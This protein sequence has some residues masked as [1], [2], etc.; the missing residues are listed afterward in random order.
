MKPIAPGNRR[1]TRPL[2]LLLAMFV[3]AYAVLAG[4]RTVSDFDLGWQL[5]TGR[6][7]LQHHQ[8]PAVD[9]FSFTAQGKPWLYPV[10]SCLLLYA[11][12]LLGGY[13][14]LSWFG[15]A[16]C[17][18]TVALLL[19]RGSV[20]TAAIAILAIPRIAA[21]TAPRAEMF[22]AVLFAAFLSVLWEYF[23]DGR[24]RLWLLPLGM[25]VWVNLHLGF[26]AGLALIGAYIGLELLELLFAGERRD[27]ALLRLRQS[28]PWLLATVA[29]SVLNPWGWNIYAALVRQNRAMAEHSQW[30][31]EWAATR[32]NWSTASAIFEL[33]TPQGAFWALLAAALLGAILAV[34]RRQFG[35]FLLLVGAT[36]LGARHVRLQALFACVVVVLSSWLI[37]SALE[38]FSDKWNDIRLKRILIAGV[39]ALLAILAMVRSADLVTNYTYLRGGDLA[40]FGP[41]LS[42]WFPERAFEFMAREGIPR[43]TLSTYNLGGFLIWRLGPR[44]RDYVDGRAI[45]FGPAIFERQFRLLSISPDAPEWTREVERYQ[46]NSIVLPIARFNGAVNSLPAFCSSLNWKPVYLDEVAAV[47]VRQSPENDALIRR[48]GLDCAKAPLPSGPATTSKVQAFNQWANAAA[49]LNVVG[50]QAEALSASS[51]ALH[52]FPESAQIHFMRGQIFTAVG[53]LHEAESEYRLSLLIDAKDVTW[54][55]LASLYR[56]EGRTAEADRAMRRAIEISSL[57]HMMLT[58]LGFDY[59]REGRGREALGAFDEAVRRAP[60]GASTNRQFQIDLLR[61]RA[62]AWSS[63]GDPFKALTFEQQAASIGTDRAEIWIELAQLYEIAGRFEEA[64]QARR[65]AQKIQTGE[66]D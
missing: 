53:S 54:A 65:R 52:I 58:N 6:W 57:P 28:W 51:N 56:L 46:I 27:K 11:G 17:V 63:M 7:I 59:A 55:S 44:Y 16:A 9:V 8:V 29:A 48:F 32:L 25:I 39:T 43:E 64:Q 41:G 14:A 49:I 21:R 26:V 62:A 60:P 3:L 20:A 5:A 1:D 50:R 33:R 35:V 45:P 15:A 24:A 66:I 23:L 36:F 4:L 30:I 37:T 42:W 12:F 34:F 18:A 19:R 40:V 22:T 2:L 61:G 10:G 31:T 38:D 47:F 13:A